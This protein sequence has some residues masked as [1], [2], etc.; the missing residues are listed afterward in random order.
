MRKRK[1]EISENYLERIPVR[2]EKLR[3]DQD[4]QGIVTLHV[5]NTGF[6]KKLKTNRVF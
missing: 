2:Q 5:H 3:W 1:K 4:E 6:M